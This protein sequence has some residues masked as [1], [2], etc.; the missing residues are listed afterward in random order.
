[1]RGKT[2]Q[3]RLGKPREMTYRGAV[4][5]VG[6]ALLVLCWTGQRA[7]S[8]PLRAQRSDAKQASYVLA[9]TAFPASPIPTIAAGQ[10]QIAGVDW[11]FAVRTVAGGEVEEVLRHPPLGASAA[12]TADPEHLAVLESLPSCLR[13]M[14]TAD[15]VELRGWDSPTFKVRVFSRSDRTA[16]LGG[17]VA[18]PRGSDWTVLSITPAPGVAAAE[19]RRGLLPLPEPVRHIC[20]RVGAGGQTQCEVLVAYDDVDR[21]IQFWQANGWEVQRP[22]WAQ[23]H[24]NIVFCQRGDR[25]V[26]VTIQQGAEP[27][28]IVLIVVS[29]DIA[30]ATAGPASEPG[31][32]A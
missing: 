1:M 25:L 32:P 10:W 16:L 24:G 27:C 17:Y 29:A 18:Y 20:R 9:S 2:K 4:L 30:T 15:G 22:G 6:L 23:K 31:F 7:G 8:P 14:G 3:Y 26:Q 19:P 28:R 11:D 13:S 21:L 5:V 12:G